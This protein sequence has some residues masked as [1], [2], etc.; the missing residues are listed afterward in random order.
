MKQHGLK[1]KENILTTSR[2]LKGCIQ[3]IMNAKSKENLRAPGPR[4]NAV[5][6]Q[7]PNFDEKSSV[8]YQII[9][10][11]KCEHK[12]KIFSLSMLFFFYFFMVLY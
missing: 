8:Q 6:K 7:L 5:R 9:P 1:H 3:N 2:K 12:L 10:S 4:S 11:I